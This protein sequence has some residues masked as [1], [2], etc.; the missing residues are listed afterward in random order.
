MLVFSI[1]KLQF[2]PNKRKHLISVLFL[3][4]PSPLT[5]ILLSVAL[6]KNQNALSC[7]IYF[8]MI[9]FYFWSYF[10]LLRN[11]FFNT[12]YFT[13]SIAKYISFRFRIK[14]KSWF[15]MM[16]SFKTMNRTKNKWNPSIYYHNSCFIGQ[17]IIVIN[18]VNL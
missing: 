9:N 14:W 5:N 15:S 12:I 7:V 17:V 3:A 16:K 2:Y 6:G 18:S 8:T 13:V 4:N 11:I 10:H 1:F